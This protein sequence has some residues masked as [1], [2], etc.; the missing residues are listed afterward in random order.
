[1]LLLKRLCIYRGFKHVIT[2]IYSPKL[3]PA[4]SMLIGYANIGD[5]LTF[6][7]REKKIWVMKNLIYQLDYPEDKGES[8][9]SRV[10]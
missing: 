5:V 6:P 1:M 9:T 4:R 10:T 8:D 2:T 3:G 7:M